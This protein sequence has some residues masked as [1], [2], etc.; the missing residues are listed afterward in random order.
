MCSKNLENLYKTASSLTTFFYFLAFL[1]LCLHHATADKFLVIEGTCVFSYVENLGYTCQLHNTTISNPTDVLEIAGNH[2][3]NH[4]DADV[5]SVR[6]LGSDIRHLNGEILRKFQNLKNFNLFSSNL[7]TINTNAFEFC[8]QLKQLDI[9]SYKLTELPNQ[10]LK[11]CENLKSIFFNFELL[12]EIPENLF[13]STK[14]LEDFYVQGKGLTTVPEKLLWNMHKLKG[15]DV[16][17]NPIQQ[18]SRYLLMYAENLESFGVTLENFN[19]QQTLVDVLNVHSN[20]KRLYLRSS[21]FKIFK[22]DFLSNFQKLETL[23]ISSWNYNLTKI[24]WK[25]L[26]S[27]L[28]DLELFKIGEEIPE[29]AFSHLVNLKSLELSGLGIENL[30][31]D[32]FKPLSNLEMLEVTETSIKTLHP[33]LFINQGNLSNLRLA[34]NKIEEFPTGIFAPLVNIGIKHEVHGIILW[35]NKI[36]RLN[37]NAFGQHPHLRYIQFSSN[38]INEIERGIFGKFH[39]NLKCAD[40]SS[41]KCIDET[42]DNATDLD[43]NESFRICFENWEETAKTTTTEEVSMIATTHD[44]CGYN[45]R[46]FEI[47]LLIFGEVL[48]NFNN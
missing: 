29:D 19:D 5:Q 37:A 34:S 15:F 48:V 10:M 17:L 44:G 40:F 42:F 32:T 30:H 21:K 43:G 13:G 27:S 46:K 16:S 28:T 3:E 24:P 25:L 31:K 33:E 36:Q 7:L 4:T 23:Y 22:F 12:R 35:Y 6:T 39:S 1:T 45:F 8:P 26:P 38:Q 18:L 9:L 2:L 11:N 14:N 47:F 20:L 41:N